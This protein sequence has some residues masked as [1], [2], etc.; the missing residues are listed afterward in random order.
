MR[1]KYMVIMMVYGAQTAS[2]YHDANVALAAMESVNAAVGFAEL[3]EYDEDEDGYV[4]I[5]T[6]EG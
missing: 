6:T 1:Y 3:Y 2:F 4:R 5:A